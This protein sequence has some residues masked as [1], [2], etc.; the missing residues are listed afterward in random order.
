[1][2]T[3]DTWLARHPYL[4]PVADL[5]A[6]VHEALSTIGITPAAALN[7]DTYRA[8]YKSG[9]PLLHSSALQFDAERLTDFLMELLRKVS[10]RSGADELAS[11]CR[12]LHAQFSAD[13]ES[14]PRAVAALLQ[15]TEA[16]DG[17]LGSLRYL[18]WKVLRVYFAQILR[19]FDDW[20]P[21]DQWLLSYCP[22]CASLPTMAQLTGREPGRM[23]HLHCPCCGTR[24]RFRR[25]GCPFC[26]R[27]DDHRLSV[28]AIEGEGG[29]RLDACESCNGYLK[30]Y[31]GEGNEALFFSDWA[32]LHLDVLAQDRQL[33]CMGIPIFD[34]AALARTAEHA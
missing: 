31:D 34:I 18:A 20:R 19:A 2:L 30:T 23:R 3:R 5:D 15:Q 32:S 8:D 29:L 24:W 4:R 16:T 14:A 22:A 28:I 17:Q 25:T 10:L 26:E 6:S 33:V 13:R 21:E 9:V 11:E 7:F 27:T 1:M 12:F